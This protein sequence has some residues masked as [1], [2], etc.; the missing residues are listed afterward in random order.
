V[1]AVKGYD[2]TVEGPGGFRAFSAIMASLAREGLSH[3][4]LPLPHDAEV[5]ALLDPFVE[6]LVEFNFVVIRFP[7]APP[8]PPGPIYLDIRH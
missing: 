8:V 2:V 6:D 4:L 7:E 1:R 5:R 3:L